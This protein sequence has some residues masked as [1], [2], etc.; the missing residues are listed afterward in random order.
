VDRPANG[1]GKYS[2]RAKIQLENDVIE[3]LRSHA[4]NTFRMIFSSPPSTPRWETELWKKFNEEVFE[5]YGIR[6]WSIWFRMLNN[7]E[8]ETEI[9]KKL[10]Q[11]KIG[12]WVVLQLL[13]AAGK[14]MT[15]AEIQNALI[16][17]GFTKL[18]YFEDVLEPLNKLGTPE[19]ILTK[20]TLPPAV[21]GSRSKYISEFSNAYRDFL[22]KCHQFE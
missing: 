2:V 22:D 3:L 5:F 19:G 8:K 12:V 16:E 20:F 13:L 18:E 10:I 15:N 9:E 1:A 7:L 11:S 21:A 4:T 6:Y 17:L 14:G